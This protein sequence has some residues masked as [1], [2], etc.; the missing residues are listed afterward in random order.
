MNLIMRYGIKLYYTNDP[1]LGRLWCKE[2]RGSG[3][4]IIVEDLNEA[5]R[6]RNKKYEQYSHD[7]RYIYE[8][9]EYKE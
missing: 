5:Y 7:Q 9:E 3:N 4:I 2:G 6:W 8:V 1:T